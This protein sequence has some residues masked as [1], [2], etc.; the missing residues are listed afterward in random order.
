[1]EVSQYH[2]ENRSLA[3]CSVFFIDRSRM[4]WFPVKPKRVIPFF[5]P[6]S[7]VTLSVGTTY[8]TGGAIPLREVRAPLVV[9]RIDSGVS[10][11]A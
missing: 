7:C 10:I 8:L 1:M 3:H 6:S 11:N 2:S 4:L 5:C 9:R